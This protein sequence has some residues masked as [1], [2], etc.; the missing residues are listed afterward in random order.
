MTAI[1]CGGGSV[2][3][4]GSGNPTGCTTNHSMVLQPFTLLSCPFFVRVQSSSSVLRS[5]FP[6]RFLC[7]V[8]VWAR[9]QNSNTEPSGESEHESRTE[10]AEAAVNGRPGLQPGAA[11]TEML[12]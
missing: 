11:K 3:S 4:N 8:Q 5:V 10:N 9:T 1:T 12:K 6:V 7:S 2:L